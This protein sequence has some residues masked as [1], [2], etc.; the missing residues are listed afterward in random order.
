[1]KG[2]EDKRA[3]GFI[4]VLQKKKKGRM[5]KNWEEGGERRGRK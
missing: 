4:G 3:Q 5:K 1:V 2:E